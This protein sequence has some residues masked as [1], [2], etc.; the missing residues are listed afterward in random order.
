M[1]Q[2]K[3]MDTAYAIDLQNKTFNEWFVAI[4]IDA[5]TLAVQE[6]RKM[7]NAEKLLAIRMH[8]SYSIGCLTSFSVW[9]CEQNAHFIASNCITDE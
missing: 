2:R 6:N 5:N 3:K 7:E 1:G 4:F 9:P 8:F